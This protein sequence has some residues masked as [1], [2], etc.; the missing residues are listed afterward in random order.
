MFN[1][2]TVLD[3]FHFTNTLESPFF[4]SV[5]RRKC[6]VKFGGGGTQEDFGEHLEPMHR[7]TS[8]QEFLDQKQK[9]LDWKLGAK[10]HVRTANAQP[11][12]TTSSGMQQGNHAGFHPLHQ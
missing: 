12:N 8:R 10:N 2:E 3:S 6:S 4:H 1:A 5:S 9:F 11:G 7:I